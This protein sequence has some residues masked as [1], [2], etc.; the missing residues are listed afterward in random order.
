M[1]GLLG[2]VKAI[3]L[4]VEAPSLIGV[5]AGNKSSV[6][7]TISLILNASVSELALG[8][9]RRDPVLSSPTHSSLSSI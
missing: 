4:D 1:P 2:L 5:I 9:L 6:R 7:S 8:K 3:H